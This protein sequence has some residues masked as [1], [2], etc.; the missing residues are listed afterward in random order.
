MTQPTFLVLV[1]EEIKEVSGAMRY[2]SLNAKAAGGRVALLAVVEPE[3]IGTWGGVDKVITDDAFDRMRQIVTH[4][5]GFVKEVSG[6][7]PHPLYIKG[8]R[9]EA[10]LDVIENEPGISALVLTSDAREDGQNAL[11]QYFTG[12][13]GIKKLTVPLIVVPDSFYEEESSSS[14]EEEDVSH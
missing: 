7:D 10:L 13:K 9:R 8:I 1:P 4:F 2:A 3:E 14:E 12:P 6:H 11:I 5:S